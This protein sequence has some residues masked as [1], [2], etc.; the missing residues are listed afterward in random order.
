MKAIY[1]KQKTKKKLYQQIPK[2]RRESSSYTAA[3]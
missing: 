1:K 3:V 2:D